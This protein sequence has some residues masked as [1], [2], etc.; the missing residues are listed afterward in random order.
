MYQK[1]QVLF[2]LDN[3]NLILLN[4]DS[5]KSKCKKVPTAKTE[6]EVDPDQ[7]SFDFEA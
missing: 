7:L 3:Q 4:F 2:Y 1:R 5:K 6:T